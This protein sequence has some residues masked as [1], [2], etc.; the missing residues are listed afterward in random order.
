MKSLK[1]WKLWKEERWIEL[2]DASLVSEIS[3]TQAMRCVNIGLICVQENADD[4]PTMSDVVCMLSSES[5]SLSKPN[6][7]AYFH[8]RVTNDVALAVPE[9]SSIND[10]TISTICGR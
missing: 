3:T 7:P 5:I 1:A 9:P 2:I 4:R 8:I 6:Y 10:M